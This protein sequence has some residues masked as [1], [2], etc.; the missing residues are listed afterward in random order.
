METLDIEVN[1]NENG[2][3]DAARRFILETAKWAKFLAIVGFV[4]LGLAVIAVI[5]MLIAGAALVSSFP[6]GGAAVGG[7]G[8]MALLYIAMIALY[9]FPTFYLYKFATKMKTGILN[10]DNSNIDSG[11]ENLKSTFK[12]MGILMIVVLSFYALAILLALVGAAIR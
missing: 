1:K 9:F 6:G 10:S 5:F 2:L 7:L 8:F 4:M 3:S 12:F 11:F